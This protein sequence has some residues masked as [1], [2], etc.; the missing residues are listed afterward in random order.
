MSNERR[1]EVTEEN[2]RPW[3][4]TVTSVKQ[5]Q[6]SGTWLEVRRD[7]DG[8][9]YGVPENLVRELLGVVS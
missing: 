1:V 6:L 7:D 4:G 2:I 8:M 5:S 9:T 3:T